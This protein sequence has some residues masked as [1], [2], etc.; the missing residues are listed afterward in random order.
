MYCKGLKLNLLG[1][2]ITDTKEYTFI[3]RNE[4]DKPKAKIIQPKNQT[5]SRG[6]IAN[7]VHQE[8]DYCAPLLTSPGNN[9]V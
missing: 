6:V 5:V 3:I 9:C 1:K 2:S 7:V 8:N 4:W